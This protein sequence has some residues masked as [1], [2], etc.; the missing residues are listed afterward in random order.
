MSHEPKHEWSL[1]QACASMLGSAWAL[2]L[3]VCHY[4]SPVLV[5]KYF[6][7]DNMEFSDSNSDDLLEMSI[8]LSTKKPRK[9]SKWCRSWLLK[10][11]EMHSFRLVYDIV[12]Y[13]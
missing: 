9:M 8:C 5:C 7:R 2:C 1:M 11:G 6:A 12:L 10:R 3:P 13:K 4:T